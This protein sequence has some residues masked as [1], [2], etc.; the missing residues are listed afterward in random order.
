MPADVAA[1]L[2]NWSTVESSNAPTGAN[3]VGPNLDDNLRTIQAVVRSAVASQTTLASAAT[4]DIGAVDAGTITITGTTTITGFGTVSA[5]IRKRLIFN[6]ALLLTHNATSLILPNNGNNITTIANDAAEFES[7]GSGNWRCVSYTRSNGLNVSNANGIGDGTV[8]APGLSFATD[9]DTGIYR[10]GANSM[11]FSAGG[12]NRMTISDTTVTVTSGGAITLQP[13]SATAGTGIDVT[14]A[15]RD[16][17]TTSL[18]GDVVIKPGK[19]SSGTNWGN[20]DFYAQ[21]NAVGGKAFF[22]VDGGESHLLLVDPSGI[23]VAPTISSGGGTGPTIAGCDNAFKI[24]LGTSP[25]TT[26]V[27]VNFGNAFANAPIVQAQYQSSNIGLAALAT[28]SS[29]TITPASTMASGGVIDVLV[30][31]RVTA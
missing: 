5:G 25:G 27:V 9:T 8:G 10:V 11:G 15:G 1:S 7:L 3:A 17:T 26:A 22:R 31:G 13:L 18:A 16:S 4:T 21:Q 19:P 30:F 28:T 23:G 12:V 2:K 14:V 24:T 6:D 20:V 29:V